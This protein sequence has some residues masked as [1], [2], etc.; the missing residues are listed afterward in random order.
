MIG[1][2]RGEALGLAIVEHGPT[3][4]LAFI[5]GVGLGLGLFVLLQPGLGLD[6]LVGSR[7]EVPLTADPRMLGLIFAAVLAIATIGI[8][9]AAWMQRRGVAVAALRRGF[10]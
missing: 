3:V 2:S 5:A 4:L 1:L 8:G 9:L 6:A 7:L 10:E